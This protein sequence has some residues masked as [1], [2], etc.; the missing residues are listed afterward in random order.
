MTGYLSCIDIKILYGTYFYKSN[1]AKEYDM[2]VAIVLFRV[3]SDLIALKMTF[4]FVQSDPYFPHLL[5][6]FL[7]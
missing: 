2:S 1:G 5:L 7:F 6:F 4:V 3:S